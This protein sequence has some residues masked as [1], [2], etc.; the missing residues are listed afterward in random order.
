MAFDI[1]RNKRY[2]ILSI[3]NLLKSFE[4]NYIEKYDA[5][6][7][8][9]IGELQGDS[10]KNIVSLYLNGG[11]IQEF[12]DE[13]TF[14]GLSLLFEL[15][16]NQNP[17]EIDWNEARNNYEES[18]KRNNES[19][20][21][22]SFNEEIKTRFE[23]ASCDELENYSEEY[24]FEIIKENAR[25]KLSEKGYTDNWY[26]QVSINKSENS[27]QYKMI[28][29]NKE[30]QTEELSSCAEI[31]SNLIKSNYSKKTDYNIKEKEGIYYIEF[32]YN[33]D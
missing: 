8:W 25:E 31:L 17:N 24:Y 13:K 12:S 23:P 3:N 10:L 14:K 22:P 16:K 6:Y 15:L 7:K 32:F 30:I 2:I 27:F 9:K 20:Y 4:G 29:V 18:L 21:L 28:A 19:L 11:D 26:F 33:M 5:F 1:K